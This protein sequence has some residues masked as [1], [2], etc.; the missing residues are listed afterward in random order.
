MKVRLM[1][2]V[3]ATV[4]VAA[5]CGTAGMQMQDGHSAPHGSGHRE[6]SGGPGVHAMSGMEMAGMRMGG[7]SA[8]GKPSAAAA[9]ICSAET[10]RAVKRALALDAVPMRQQMWMPPIFGCTW[11]L[12]HGRLQL[13]VD[14][15]TDPAKGHR[16]FAQM[17]VT[18]SGAEKLGGMASFG[19]PAFE[20]SAGMVVFLK[21]GKVLSVDARRVAGQ[22]LPKGFSREDVAYGVASAV[23]ACWS[24]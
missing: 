2:A 12:P 4:A 24:E 19:F 8:S 14:D 17:M 16:R 3:V 15:A 7:G 10:G 6:M 20:S 11:Q 1:T 18:V 5:G 22:D 13:A 21:D 23:I 9:M